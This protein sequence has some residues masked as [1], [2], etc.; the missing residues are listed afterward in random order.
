MDVH[1]VLITLPLPSTYLALPASIRL[2]K[3]NMSMDTKF[4]MADAWWDD[5]NIFNFI[6]IEILA[7]VSTPPYLT[8]DLWGFFSSGSGMLRLDTKLKN[9]SAYMWLNLSLVTVL[10]VSLKDKND[11]LH[12][13]F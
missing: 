9:F 13:K 1:V 11:W 7:F 10:K 8:I 3:T 4:P 2:M 12:D 5:E 6:I